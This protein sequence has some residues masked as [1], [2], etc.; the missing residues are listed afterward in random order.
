MNARFTRWAL[1]VNYLVTDRRIYFNSLLA[2]GPVVHAPREFSTA[3]RMHL[4]IHFGLTCECV[5]GVSNPGAPNRCC[6][7]RGDRLPRAEK[8]SIPTAN[9][10]T[11]PLQKP[12]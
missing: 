2:T 6:F 9:R 11:Q 8:E 7:R 1:V 5:V 12:K 10:Q 3:S 4:Y